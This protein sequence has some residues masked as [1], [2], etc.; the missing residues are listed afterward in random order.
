MRPPVENGTCG[1]ARRLFSVALDG[2]AAASDV[3]T[4]AMHIARCERC[5]RFAVRVV[6]LT[7]ELRAV[8]HD[9]SGAPRDIDYSRGAGT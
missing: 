2:E 9:G 4:A 3:L 1:G 6:A 8:R 5:Q 7:R